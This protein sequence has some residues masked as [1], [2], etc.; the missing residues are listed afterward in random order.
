MKRE[1]MMLT[2]ERKFGIGQPARRVEDRRF[3]TG[4]GRYTADLV[5]PGAAVG[6]VLRATHAHARFRLSGVEEARAAPGALAILTYAD[7]SDLGDLPCPGAVR[8]ADG[9]SM[10]LP[11]YP[12]LADGIARHVGDALAFVVAADEDAAREA[13]EAIIV[14]YEPLA[15]VVGI[16]QARS[17]AALVWPEF[18][19][20]LA[21]DASHGDAAETDAAFADAHRVVSLDLV[22]NRLVANYVEPRACL[23]VYDA[24][25]Q[26]WTLTLGS[27]GSH[28]MRDIIADDVLKVDR[29]R[30]RVITPDVGGG[31]GTKIFVYREYPLCAVAAR[32]TG[33][34]V[35]WVCDRNEHFVADTQGRDNLVRAEMALDRDGRFLGLRVDI[36]ADLGAYLSQFAP[37]VPWGGARMAPGCYDIPAVHARVRGYYT[38]TIPV[39]AYRGA[40]RPEAA[41]MIERLVDH[42]AHEIGMSPDALRALNF[43]KSDQMP[44][45]TKTGRRYDA[46]DFEGAMRR[47]MELADWAG[48]PERL[49]ASRMSG[50]IRG[51][52][53]ASYIE[54]C[55]GGSPEEATITLDA[56]GVAHVLIGTQSTGQGHLTAY[57]QIVSQHL[58]LPLDRVVVFQGDTALIATGN[59][60]GGSRSIPVGGAAVDGAAR[61]LAQRVLELGG[62]LLEAELGDLEIADGGV[63]V[64]GTDQAVPLER[65]V[66]RAAAQGETLRAVQSWKPPEA[67]YPNGTHICEVEIDPETGHV[68]VARYTVVDDFGVT[69]NPLLLAGQVHG[70]VAQGIGQALHERTLFDDTGQLVTASFMDYRLP[71]AEDLPGFVFETRNIRSTTNLLGMKGAGEAGTVGSAPAVMNAVVDA[72]RRAYGVTGLDMPATPDRV[73]ATI[74]AARSG[75]GDHVRV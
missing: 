23:A 16:A 3:V 73:F 68:D 60:T 64:A 46:G 39:D 50:M 40:G 15:P 26:S 9:S 69:L 6:V 54:A 74:R 51:V 47:A 63:R 62:E 61:T 72:L 41:Y 13:A 1:I 53:M 8:N 27:Q 2:D 59:G 12:I 56:G 38:N 18:E 49:V 65:I 67:T 57:A 28:D 4:E 32:L 21:F 45:R 25:G 42:V 70:G 44:H 11:R 7:V 71:R 22:N 31:F 20:N 14:E 58:D 55:A 52:G 43:V 75:E 48:F 33:R 10:R 34:P 24:D 66:A 29:A 37:F 36:E 5:P 35:A 19:T 17:N 30:V